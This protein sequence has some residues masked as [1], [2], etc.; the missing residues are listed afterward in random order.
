MMVPWHQVRAEVPHHRSG[1]RWY[2]VGA[3]R[4]RGGYGPGRAGGRGTEDRHH[5]PA[6]RRQSP[7]PHRP[8]SDRHP[9]DHRR[10]YQHRRHDNEVAACHE[11]HFPL[12]RHDGNERRS[13]VPPSLNKGR[14]EDRRSAQWSAAREHHGNRPD[15]DRTPH[16]H[17]PSDPS[18]RRR[19]GERVVFRCG[20]STSSRSHADKAGI[21]RRSRA[22]ANRPRARAATACP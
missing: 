8:A 17:S 19:S 5:Q 3:R 14:V 20:H 7:A 16:E 4:R 11:Q 9:S 15:D 22:P 6:A 18:H 10:H 13:S 12:N 1:P 2:R 21:T